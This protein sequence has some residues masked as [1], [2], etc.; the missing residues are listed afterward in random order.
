MSTTNRIHI[1]EASA[2]LAVGIAVAGYF[3][4]QTLYNAKVAINTAEV[5]GLAERRVKADS[6]FWRID[7]TVSGNEK[8]AV[9]Q[10]YEESEADREKVVQLLK[11]NGFDDSEIAPGVITYTEQE[12]RDEN[13]KLVEVRYILRGAIDVET[14]QVELVSQVR[15]KLNQLMAQGLDLQNNPPSYYFTQLNQIKPEMLQEAT[16]NAR[17]AA[18]E[19]ASNAGVSVG[20]IREARQGNFVIRDVGQSYGDTQKIDKDVRVVTTITFYL[21]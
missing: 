19:F 4:G 12:F 7:Y 16:K 9:P 14:S 3:V 2:L 17:A 21:D 8:A 13:Q 20:G 1:L 10:L 11:E 18:N 6:A 15:S 5:K